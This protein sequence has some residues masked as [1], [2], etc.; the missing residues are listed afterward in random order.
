M[1]RFNSGT[2]E[3]PPSRRILAFQAD[4]FHPLLQ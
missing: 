1:Q 2:R 4:I 3:I